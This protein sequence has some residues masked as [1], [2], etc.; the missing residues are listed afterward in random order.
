MIFAERMGV[1][2]IDKIKRKLGCGIC[3]EEE[4]PLELVL[5]SH[6]K[7]ETVDDFDA[8]LMDYDDVMGMGAV[9]LACILKLR[10]IKVPPIG[11]KPTARA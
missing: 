3:E 10:E 8:I 4:D 1:L 6:R 9:C 7:N 5:W 11:E 2:V